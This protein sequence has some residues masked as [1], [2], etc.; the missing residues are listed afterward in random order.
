MIK[1][2]IGLASLLVFNLQAEVKPEHLNSAVSVTWHNPDKFLDV[3]AGEGNQKR[4][5]QRVL[6]SLERYLHQQL[7]KV[8]ADGQTIK[9]T[10]HDL[11]MAGDVRPWVINNQEI[12]II[13]SIYPPMIDIE[14]SL[15]AQ[16]GSLIDSART[17]V[18]DMGFALMTNIG[19]RSNSFAY[20]KTMLKSWM[21]KQL[22]S[23]L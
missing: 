3:D 15:F 8:I 19:S 9:I 1:F 12:R 4:F 17:K 11:D 10:V 18:R 6:D 14:Y 22:K 2:I 20:E 13:K 23:Q 21:K 16:D 5:Q 7:P